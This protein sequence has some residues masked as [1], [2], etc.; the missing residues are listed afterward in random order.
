MARFGM[1][2]VM[3]VVPVMVM[4]GAGYQKTEPR[5]NQEPESATIHA[6]FAEYWNL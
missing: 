2:P 3:S 5:E 6:R 4:V 1:I